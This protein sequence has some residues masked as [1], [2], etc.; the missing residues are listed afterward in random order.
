M[1]PSNQ[2][3]VGLDDFLVAEGPERLSDLLEGAA[4]L[5]GWAVASV[6]GKGSPVGTD[7]FIWFVS[8]FKS[9]GAFEQLQLAGSTAKRI[10]LT[11]SEFHIILREVIPWRPNPPRA[12]REEAARQREKEQ[13]HR[14]KTEDEIHSAAMELVKDPAVLHLAIKAV[15]QLGVAGEE[16]NI[17]ITRLTVRSRALRRPVNEQ[18]HSPSSTGKTH[19]VHSTLTL[20][21]PSAWYELT[22]ST[23]KALIYSSEPLEHRILYIQEPEGIGEGVGAAAIKSLIWEG[24]LRYD[25]VV[26]EDGEFVVQ[27]IEKDGPTGL[28][29]TTTRNLEEQISNRMFRTELDPSKEQ[30]RRI[31]YSIAAGAEGTGEEPDVEIWREFSKITGEPIDVI[32]PFASWLAER[33]TIGTL[34]IRRDFTQF[35]NFIR[36]SAV[37]HRYQRIGLPD[38]SIQASVADYAM[39]HALVAD[40]FE[41]AQ[42]EGITEA[43]RTFLKAVAECS[44]QLGRSPSQADLVRHMKSSKGAVSNRA[45]RL[46]N[47]GY[48]E[49]HEERQRRAAKLVIGTPPPDPVP[50]LPTP[51]DLSTYVMSVGK[52]DL[53]QSWIHPITGE[54]H[55][56]REHMNGHPAMASRRYGE[57]F[58]AQMNGG[59]HLNSTVQPLTTVQSHH[60]RSSDADIQGFSADRSGVQSE[61]DG[62]VLEI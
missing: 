12:E 49:N 39:V 50:P 28:I 4:D 17:G 20:E 14:Q 27:H 41:A 8:R 40:L 59:E 61:T 13:A 10:G 32:I 56:C 46:L 19:V 35:L 55:D 16:R 57:P 23:E 42:G 11:K 1:S 43:D 3:K 24:R 5:T 31:L 22:G 37:E 36:A 60:E 26:K 7:D 48:L 6:S 33:V 2:Q 18:V 30:T 29:V 34:R 62:D 47:L 51:C 52:S 58:M 44:E 53:L 38:G 25:T 15:G 9:L 54:R 45:T 21:H